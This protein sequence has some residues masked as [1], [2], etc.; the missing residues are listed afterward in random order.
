MWKEDCRIMH[1]ATRKYLSV[2]G[3]APNFEV[4]CY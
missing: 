2:S 4:F 1:L 3:E